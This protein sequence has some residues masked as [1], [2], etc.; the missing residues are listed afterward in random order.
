MR[1]MLYVLMNF[2]SKKEDRWF[3][4]LTDTILQTIKQNNANTTN[5]SVIY[6]MQIN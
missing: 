1:K 4:E 2:E 3:V 5:C 6:L